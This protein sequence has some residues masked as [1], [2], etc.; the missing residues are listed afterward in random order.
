MAKNV[1]LDNCILMELVSPVEF[2]GYL[3]QVIAWHNNKDIQLYCPDTLKKEWEVHRKAKMNAIEQILKNHVQALKA[4]GLLQHPADI[5]DAQLSEAEKILKSQIEAIDQIL[6]ECVQVKDSPA[7]I[8]MLEHQSERKAPFHSKTASQHDAII[9]FATLEMLTGA[10]EQELYFFSTNHTDYGEPGKP[11]KLHADIV[12]AYPGVNVVYFSNLA[13]GIESLTKL[14]L[15]STKPGKQSTKLVKELIFVDKKKTMLQQLYDY[16]HKRFD[17]MRVLP[18]AL[19]ARHYPFISG[20]TD[21]THDRAFNLNTNNQELFDLFVH[22]KENELQLP[23]H[24]PPA[25]TVAPEQPYEKEADILA[26]LRGCQVVTISLNN[27]RTVEL[28]VPAGRSCSCE[29][30]SFRQHEFMASFALVAQLT[31]D[32]EPTLKKAYAFYLTGKMGSAIKVLK[33]VAEEAAENKKWLRLYIAK[34]NLYLLG[35]LL[36]YRSIPG[37][38]DKEEIDQLRNI[39]MEDVYT[40]C[41]SNSI[42]EI[43]DQLKEGHFM[44]SAISQAK[45]LSRQI[46]DDKLDRNGGWNDKM[47]LLLELY[48]STINMMEE[49]YIMLDEFSDATTLTEYLIEALFASYTSCKDLG[50]KVTHFSDSIVSKIVTHAKQDDII[51]FRNRFHLRLGKYISESAG[52]DFVKR[53]CNQ[54]ENYGPAVEFYSRP[55]NP[56]PQFFWRR[57]KTTF[58]NALTM[59]SL[60]DITQADVDAICHLLLPFLRQEQ[61]FHE[62]EITKTVCY[63]LKNHSGMIS[64]GLLEEFL[65]FAYMSDSTRRDEMIYTL[66]DISRKRQLDLH[67]SAKQWEQLQ[68]LYLINDSLT[69][70]ASTI[71]EICCLYGFL[72]KPVYKKEITDF[73]LFYLKKQFNTDVYYTAVIHKLVKS[74]AVR[75]AKYRDKMIALAQ[76][77]KRPRIFPSSFYTDHRLDEYINFQF[78]FNQPFDARFMEAVEKLDDYYFWITAIDSF[79]YQRF[80]PDW[81]FNHL[82]MYY[83]EQFRSSKSLR[84]WLRKHLLGSDDARLARLFID[85]YTK[86]E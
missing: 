6:F 37:I 14:G 49:N 54:L 70:E 86:A 65:L 15:P 52:P 13:K 22:I 60:L 16:L 67:V 26:L 73:L 2:N 1:L 78:A 23:Q 76:E 47:R 50:G 12:T 31:D 36:Q 3:K 74:S 10:G 35:R 71:N 28:A 40:V 61:H 72:K 44:Q 85:L 51:K 9:L 7:G 81:L 32:T 77:G 19:F 80:D 75:S 53:F 42:D 5:S 29:V 62:H 69:Q 30:C 66:A 38:R 11:E 33:S 8:M 59:A 56:E 43:L 83:K 48:F 39:Q 63:F 25:G 17:E 68:A 79:D 64:K 46:Q 27:S 84:N 34:Y 45:E 57:F 21:D 58:H 18:K 82:T 4:A 55:E 24:R 41:L 20:T